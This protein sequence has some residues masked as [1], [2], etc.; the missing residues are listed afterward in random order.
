MKICNDTLKTI[1]CLTQSKK[2]LSS[3]DT[4][5]KIERTERHIKHLVAQFPQ[6]NTH[7]GKGFRAKR[8]SILNQISLASNRLT[9]LRLAKVSASKVTDSDFTE[10]SLFHYLLHLNDAPEREFEEQQRY[11]HFG[12]SNKFFGGSGEEER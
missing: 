10:K 6:R 4:D 7:G 12:M 9:S 3:Q 5:K 2:L 8:I 11:P 1:S